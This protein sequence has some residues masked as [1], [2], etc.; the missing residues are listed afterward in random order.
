MFMEGRSAEVIFNGKSVGAIGEI[1][2]RALENFKL[3]TPVGAFELNLLA[4]IKE[5]KYST[6]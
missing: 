1:I 2:P 5:D 4:L 6:M 3:R